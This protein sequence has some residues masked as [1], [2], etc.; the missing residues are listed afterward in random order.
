MAMNDDINGTEGLRDIV[1][2]IRAS[3]H[4]QL[5]VALV[6]SVLDVQFQ[7]AEDRAEAEKR[8]D[9]LISAWVAKQVASGSDA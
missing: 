1:E 9:Q 5:D 2:A 7:F 3:D 8:T 6:S 4:P